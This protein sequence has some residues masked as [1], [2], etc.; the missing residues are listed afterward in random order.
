[1]LIQPYASC[2]PLTT[3][4][5]LQGPLHVPYGQATHCSVTSVLFYGRAMSGRRCWL[6]SLLILTRT[7]DPKNGNSRNGGAHPKKVVVTA[8]T[9]HHWLA[10]LR[11]A[12]PSP[13]H[14]LGMVLA[15]FTHHFTTVGLLTHPNASHTLPGAPWGA[16]IKG[17][18]L[19]IRPT[20]RGSPCGLTFMSGP[21][22]AKDVTK[23]P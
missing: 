17:W 22:H 2:H 12:S 5:P 20:G 3:H 16:F 4:G 11:A 1:M 15:L 8:H 21:G 6:S 9:Y 19:S 18:R 10:T 23:A 14:T 7:S 13:L